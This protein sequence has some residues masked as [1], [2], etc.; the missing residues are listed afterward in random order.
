MKR[1]ERKLCIIMNMWKTIRGSLN[2]QRYMH[3]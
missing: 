3:V 1:I 2:K